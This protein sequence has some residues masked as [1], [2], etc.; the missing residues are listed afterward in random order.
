MCTFGSLYNT[1]Y[2]CYIVDLVLTLTVLCDEIIVKLIERFC[3]KSIICNWLLPC[4]QA[5]PC[6]PGGAVACKAVTRPLEVVSLQTDDVSTKVATSASARCSG[7]IGADGKSSSE[8]RPVLSCSSRD[9]ENSGPALWLLAPPA[10]RSV[11]GPTGG[12][13]SFFMKYFWPCS[14]WQLCSCSW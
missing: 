14:R 12:R 5:H 8:A 11:S 1:Y 3:S 13:W 2:K 10:A 9:A 7:V 6:A 4:M